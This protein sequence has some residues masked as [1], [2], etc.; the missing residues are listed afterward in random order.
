VTYLKKMIGE[1]DRDVA[2]LSLS[3]RRDVSDPEV[4]AGNA[5]DTA[6]LSAEPVCDWCGDSEP[7]VV[8]ASRRMS[9]GEDRQCWRWFACERCERMVERGNWD[10]LERKTIARY[11]KFFGAKIQAEFGHVP[12]SLVNEAV[13][14]AL[15]QF[16]DYAVYLTDTTP[17]G[18]KSYP[19][20]TKESQS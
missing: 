18:G 14:S 10:A 17:G 11:K 1:Y 20:D 9:T 3:V 15:Q 12:D 8:Y 19:A 6:R 16:H 5:V 13:A 2:R 4:N 7:V